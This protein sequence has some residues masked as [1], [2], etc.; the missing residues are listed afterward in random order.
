MVPSNVRV[1][2][3]LAA[4]EDFDWLFRRSACT[5]TQAEQGSA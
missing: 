1:D 3:A 5:A 4:P 2:G